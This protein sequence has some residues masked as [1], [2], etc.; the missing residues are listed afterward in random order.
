MTVLE[1]LT[2]KAIRPRTQKDMGMPSMNGSWTSI[3]LK[4]MRRTMY[5]HKR[6]LYTDVAHIRAL[7]NRDKANNIINL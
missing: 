6:R 7:V 2:T 5:A 1:K 3:L 4:T